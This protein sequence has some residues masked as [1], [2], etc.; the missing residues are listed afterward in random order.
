MKRWFAAALTI[1]TLAALAWLFFGD[2]DEAPL[3][4]MT[5]R[6]L[7]LE[8]RTLTTAAGEV[9]PIAYGDVEVPEV[10]GK[11]GS[12][13]IS[14]GFG[15]VPRREGAGDTPVFILAGG[16]GGSYTSGLDRVWLQEVIQLFRGLGDVVLVD[17]RGIGR[18]TPSFEIK[19]P[20]QRMRRLKDGAD[21]AALLRDAG[22]AGRAKLVEAGFDL[23]GYTVLEAAAD[24]IAV[25]DYLGYGRIHLK[26]TSFGSHLTLTTVRRFPDRVER[27]LVTGVEG[28]DHTFDDGSQ[29]LAALERIAAEAEP[30]WA[31][32]HGSANPLEALRNLAD[33]AEVDPAQALGMRPYEVKLLMT[34]GDILGFDYRL[35]EREDMGSWPADVARLL[36]GEKLWR[37]RLFRNLAGWFVGRSPS[38]AAIGLFDC[39]SYIS[40]DR[41]RRLETSAPAA[42]PNDLEMMDSLCSGWR[43]EPLPESFQAG[44]TSE[45]PGLF[46]QGTYD[47]ATP[48][49]NAV[50]TLEHFP[51]ATLITVEGGS[52]GVLKEALDFDPE[53]G[54]ALLDWFGGGPPPSNLVLGAIEFQPIRD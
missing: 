39:T 8:G 17:L 38:E 43:V 22:Q 1:T 19:G 26:G 21:L 28:Y 40:Q 2:D 23:Q 49:E 9:L 36:D 45:T 35:S 25:A 48:F 32:A 53:Y 4:P 52:H 12:R 6:G 34:S 41:R 46:L 15:F 24:I 3:E 20:A 37:L 11:P 42:F 16:P 29:V 47:V 13:M 33:R 18:S 30:V 44:E 51:N 10:R 5:Y 31:G 27:F 50:E 7:D 54:E 14:V